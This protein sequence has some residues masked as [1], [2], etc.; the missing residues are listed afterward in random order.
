MSVLPVEAPLLSPSLSPSLAFSLSLSISLSRTLSLSLS[1]SHSRSLAAQAHT[2]YK[3]IADPGSRYA[4]LNSRL[5]SN[6]GDE[7][8]N[9]GTN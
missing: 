5:Q 7:E 1:L 8:E 6:K 9:R 4:S 3:S 2:R